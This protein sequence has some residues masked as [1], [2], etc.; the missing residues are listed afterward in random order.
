MS[1]RIPA[2]PATRPACCRRKSFL[3]RKNKKTACSPL[4]REIPTAFSSCCPTTRSN[5]HRPAPLPRFL[6]THEKYGATD[7]H[8]SLPLPAFLRVA[9]AGGSPRRAHP[10]S[11]RPAARRAHP[12]N[13]VAKPLA[14]PVPFSAGKNRSERRGD[15]RLGSRRAR[16]IQ[17]LPPFL[18]CDARRPPWHLLCLQCEQSPRNR[19]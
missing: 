9:Q 3:C 1:H 7:P 13:K 15:A 10:T 19:S 11:R 12:T 8:P 5:N 6:H 14:A 17:S 16:E 18:Q 4:N 2:K